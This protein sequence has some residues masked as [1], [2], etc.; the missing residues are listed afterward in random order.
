MAGTSKVVYV[1]EYLVIKFVIY[2][3]GHFVGKTNV[4]L[5]LRNKGNSVDLIAVDTVIEG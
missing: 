2:V 1:L 3:T 4:I 5:Q